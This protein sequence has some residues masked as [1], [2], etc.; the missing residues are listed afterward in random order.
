MIDVTAPA[1]Q[2]LAADLAELQGAAARVEDISASEAIRKAGGYI[3]L[4]AA[5]LGGFLERIAAT[6][7]I[8]ARGLELLADVQ[9]AMVGVLNALDQAAAE[10]DA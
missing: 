5:D 9:R 8:D 6:A 7:A 3:G 10:V 1:R 2:A 4:A